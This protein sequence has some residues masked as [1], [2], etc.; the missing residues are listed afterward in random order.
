MI[1]TT[2]RVTIG[3]LIRLARKLGPDSAGL[4]RPGTAEDNPEYSRALIELITDA[5]GLTM[6][7]ADE[8]ASLLYEKQAGARR[9]T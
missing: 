1:D 5:A 7:S 9:Q 2:R 8:V 4:A 6:D 3:E